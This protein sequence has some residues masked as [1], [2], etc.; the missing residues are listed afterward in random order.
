MDGVRNL[1]ISTRLRIRLQL[2]N[3]QPKRLFKKTLEISLPEVLVPLADTVRNEYNQMVFAVF[4]P[5]D[6]L[7]Q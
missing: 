4:V 5:S 7:N 1:P 2:C 6:D 3:E